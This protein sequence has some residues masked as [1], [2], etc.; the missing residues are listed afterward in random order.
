MHDECALIQYR[1][2]GIE[3]EELSELEEF[4]EKYSGYN[5]EI[6]VFMDLKEFKKQ[7][8]TNFDSL[9]TEYNRTKELVK[10]RLKDV[11]NI[12]FK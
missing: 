6:R 2:S 10:Q 5:D 9:I 8:V 11:N 7:N 12:T 4:M 1:L 3:E